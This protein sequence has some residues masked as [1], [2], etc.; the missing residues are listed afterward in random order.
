ML[1]E[2]LTDK[3]QEDFRINIKKLKELVDATKEKFPN[4]Y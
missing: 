4:T 1:A 3:P 2:I